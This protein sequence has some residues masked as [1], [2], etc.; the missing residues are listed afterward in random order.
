MALWK[1]CSAGGYIRARRWLSKTTSK[2]SK[3]PIR[4]LP[5]TMTVT[6]EQIHAALGA[7]VVRGFKRTWMRLRRRE[8]SLPLRAILAKE[9]QSLSVSRMTSEGLYFQALALGQHQLRERWDVTRDS[10]DALVSEQSFSGQAVAEPA[11]EK[12]FHALIEQAEQATSNLHAWSDHSPVAGHED[13]VSLPLGCAAERTFRKAYAVFSAH[14]DMQ[15][16]AAESE[17]Q[18]ER[19][20]EQVEDGIL[21]LASGCLKGVGEELRDLQGEIDGAL[22]WLRS[23]A[24]FEQ[25]GD[26]PLPKVDVVPAASRM[27]DLESSLRAV[28][29]RLP[30]ASDILASFTAQPVRRFRFRQLRPRETMQQAFSRRGRMEILELLEKVESEHHAIVQQIER[31]RQVIA[32]ARETAK[33]GAEDEPQVAQEAVRNSLS[34]LE[35]YRNEPPEWCSKADPKL[36][37]ILASAIVENRLIL[38]MGRLGVLTYLTRQGLRRAL[39][40]AGRRL[41]GSLGRGLVRS[42]RILERAVLKVLIGIG[43]KPAPSD[44]LVD[45]VVRQYLPEEFTV[46]LASKDLP[47]LY[48]RLFR[49]NPLQDPRFLV[50]RETEMA[51]IAEARSLWEASRPVA[52]LLVGQRGSGKTSLINCALQRLLEGHETLRGEFNRRL[53][54]A[55][56]LRV[57][58]GDLFRTGDAADLET[59][60]NSRRRIVILEELERSFLRQ[61]G[62]YGAVR[63]LLRVIAA[64]SS[65]TLWILAVNQVAFRFLDAAVML[66]QSF[67]HRINAGTASRDDMRKA[68]L[69]RHNLSGLRLKIGAPPLHAGISQRLRRSLGRR[70]NPESHFFDVLARESAGVFRSAFEIW[71]GQIESIQGGA[72]HVKAL[73]P[74]DLAGIID[75][76]TLED[77]FTLVAILQ[78]GGL[79]IEEHAII[80]QNSDTI[81][82]AQLNGLQAREIIEADPAR[83]GFRVRPEAMRVVREALYQRNLL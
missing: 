76:L 40:L 43:W 79:T 13:F 49:F 83:Q 32:F 61:V 37:Q 64:T 77:L 18:L 4:G 15:G 57:F 47:V 7:R 58:L 65:S 59:F 55:A 23:L 27:A 36:G 26:F 38:G 28:L 56:E 6:G 2:V 70:D 54:T 67:S 1:M 34:L 22:A 20:I 5:E 41:G 31:A 44:D 60:L 17:L 53:V 46:D 68:I 73:S 30:M 24:S 69:L 74:P 14:W 25:D 42:F 81:S 3:S 35:Y 72:L 33:S 80:F 50:G 63:E 66:G 51:A 52:V 19:S 48:R 11:Q 39:V 10:M 75:D 8:R 82:R 29:E 9:I 12:K 62:H 16:R 45:V 21:N 71:L 78:H